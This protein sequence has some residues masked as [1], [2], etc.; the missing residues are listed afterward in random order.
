[1]NSSSK[2]VK[3]S[4]VSYL[5]TDK[6]IESLK[7]NMAVLAVGSLEQ[8][9]P[10]LPVSTDTIIAVKVAEKIA[11][12][13]GAY[14][15][16]PLPYSISIEHEEKISTVT[17]TPNILHE[18]L[19]QIATNLKQHNFKYFVIVNGHGANFILRNT[20]RWINYRI[21][22]LTIL[23]D[24]GY[25]YFGERF[26]RDIHAGR[27]ETSLMMYLAPELVRQ[28]Q[29]VDEVPCIPRDYLD[30]KPITHISKS[31]VWG[32]AKKANSEEGR[33]IF[34][35]LINMAIEEIKEVIKFK[36]SSNSLQDY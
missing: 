8:H 16:P 35:Q 20:V 18:I 26:S 34:E 10:H 31:G 32:E 36:E 3:S 11:E 5:N 25:M 19:T 33:R 24:L 30:Y 29:L 23:I 12:Y 28:D 27:I 4:Y 15:L 2:N 6:E 14:L 7:P 1:M 21:G 22:L 9:G 13:F 17:L